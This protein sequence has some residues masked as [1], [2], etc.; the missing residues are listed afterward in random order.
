MNFFY[1]PINR[2]VGRGVHGLGWVGLGGF[3]DPTHHGGFKKIQ[4]NP[5]HYRGSTQ[6]N[7]THIDWVEPMDWTIYFFYYYYY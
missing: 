6:P 4:L 5:T 3:F 7:P 2:F 1:G